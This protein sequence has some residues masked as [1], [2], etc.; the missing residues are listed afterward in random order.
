MRKHYDILYYFD[1]VHVKY[2]SLLYYYFCDF[3]CFIVLLSLI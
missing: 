3:C 2:C 1:H